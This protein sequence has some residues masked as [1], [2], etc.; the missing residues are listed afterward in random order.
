MFYF[1]NVCPAYP[2]LVP[3]ST[4]NKLKFVTLQGHSGENAKEKEKK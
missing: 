1:F 3:F 4:G 2:L